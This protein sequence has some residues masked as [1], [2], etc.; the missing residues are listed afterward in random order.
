MS[1]PKKY[2]PFVALARAAIQAYVRERKQIKPPRDLSTGCIETR[3]Q[4]YTSGFENRATSFLLFQ[5]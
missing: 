1:T 3:G 4:I 2:H 5:P